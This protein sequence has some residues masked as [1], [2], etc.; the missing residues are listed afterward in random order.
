MEGLLCFSAKSMEWN[1][2]PPRRLQ[3]MGLFVGQFSSRKRN[4]LELQSMVN[5]GLQVHDDLDKKYVA[6]VIHI[7]PFNL[8]LS[9]FFRKI[10]TRQ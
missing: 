7:E 2:I 3:E 10:N 5:G 9:F 6:K 4:R 1:W 8:F